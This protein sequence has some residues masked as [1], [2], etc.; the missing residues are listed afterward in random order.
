[1]AR[2]SAP[3]APAPGT[4]TPRN[5]GLPNSEPPQSGP[6]R[7]SRPLLGILYMCVA[8]ALFPVMNGIVK[9]LTSSYEPIQVVWFRIVVHLVL[10]ALVFTPR[11][12]L[13]LFRTQRIGLQF[14]SSVAMLLSTVL[15]FS[16]VKSVGVAEAIAVSFVSPLAVVFLAWPLLGERITALRVAAVVLGFAG[17]LVVIRPGSSVFQWASVLLVGSALA[18]ALYQIVIRR[19]AGIDQPATSIFYSV[20][21]GAILLSA[22][23]PFIWQTPRSWTDWA[24]FLSLGALGGFGHYCVAK[25]LTYASANLIAPLNYTQMIGSVIVGYLMFAEAPDIYT[26]MGTALIVCAGLLVTLQIRRPT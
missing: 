18:Y 8:C 5:S 12:G 21:L 24:L 25:A 15:F 19:L 1:M 9:L 26:W 13:D 10:V 22:V 11:M 6:T 2:P 16:A 4:P 7:V 23:V 17:V 3:A 14:V 20:L